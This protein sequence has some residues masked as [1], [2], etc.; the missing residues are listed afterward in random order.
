[1]KKIGIIVGSIILLFVVVSSIVSTV[2][3]N[4]NFP[5]YERH[6]DTINA[7]LRYND[8]SEEYPRE[9]HSI[10]SGD[11]QL[12]GYH[13][14]VPNP[15]ALLVLSHGIGGGADSYISYIKWFLDQGFSVFSY[16]ATGSFDSEGKSTKGFPQSLIDLEAVLTYIE[17]H[18]TL[19][20]QDK[21]LFG[22][23]WGGYA[24][25]NVLHFDFD[26]KAV[27]SVAA[28]SSAN[29]MIFEQVERSLGVFGLTQRPFLSL[30]QSLLFGKYAKFDAIDAL[31]DTE[32]HVMIVH[33]N[34]DEM[35]N[36]QKSAIFAKYDSITNTNV[37]FILREEAGRNGH[38]N[39]FRSEDA[40]R[41]IDE[42][43]LDYR[44]LY[45]LHNQNIPYEI[46]QEFYASLDRFLVQELDEEF[47]Q[48]IL[49]FYLD[50][51]A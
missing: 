14:S 9:L 26:I 41:Y 24:V 17:E 46:N 40:I 10:T 23:S 19:S 16:D 13:Y 36:Y 5:R 8:I 4:Q 43:N 27:V 6:D 44:A 28:P 38:N 35:V 1:M 20:L 33:G 30:Y 18:D 11:N 2:V 45:D 12:S 39:L 7:M 37:I 48:S 15:I 32:V 3:Y 49:V 34:E 22:H 47:M 42:I 31:V 21:V 51:L 25:A 29:E 50:A